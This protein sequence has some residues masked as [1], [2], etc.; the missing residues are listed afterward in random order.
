MANFAQIVR[1]TSKDLDH[2]KDAVTRYSVGLDDVFNRL[3]SYGANNPGGSYPPYNLIKDSNTEWRIE[4]ALAGW[5]KDEFKVSTQSN[6]LMI[7]SIRGKEEPSSEYLHRGV[8]TRS[9]TRGFNI[10]DDVVIKDVK[11]ENG[12]LTIF[13]EKVIPEH[14]KQKVY[15]IS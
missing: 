1:Y 12:M 5:S 4:M 3:H 9:F 14:Q 7:E 8:A 11:F 2:I 13:L 15:E 6:I 10:A